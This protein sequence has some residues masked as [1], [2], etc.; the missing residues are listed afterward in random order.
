M[1]YVDISGSGQRQHRSPA[2]Q[3]QRLGA[4]NAVAEL[5]ALFA[6]GDRAGVDHPV[7]NADFGLRFAVEMGEQEDLVR[8]DFDR[9]R[10]RRK[11]GQQQC[12]RDQKFSHGLFS[13]FLIGSA[14]SVVRVGQRDFVGNDAGALNRLHM[15]VDERDVG[16]F[17]VRREDQSLIRRSSRDTQIDAA[18]WRDISGVFVTF[19]ADRI[20]EKQCFCRRFFQLFQI[21][22]GRTDFDSVNPCEPAAPEVERG[23]VRQ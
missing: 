12:G 9:F 23:V 22:P 15:T 5:D 17:E 16:G 21:D 20:T 1:F 2:G 6:R 11:S 7:G 19:A 10:R 3:V 13:P 4:R 14:R 18:G 8:P